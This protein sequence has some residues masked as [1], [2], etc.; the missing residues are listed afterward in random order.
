MTRVILHGADAVHYAQDHGVAIHV[1]DGDEPGRS[2]SV[3]LDEARA[4]AEREPE[5]VWVEI[6]Q[7]VNT[8]GENTGPWDG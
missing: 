5:R 7:A 6:E 1:R 2:T 3:S 8:G 4:V